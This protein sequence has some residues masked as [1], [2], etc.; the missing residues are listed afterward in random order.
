MDSIQ[1]KVEYS[2]EQEASVIS[3][4]VNDESLIE[5]MKRYEAQFEPEIA[6]LYEGLNTDLVD[7]IEAHFT[8]RLQEDDIFNYEG[9][10]LVLGCNCGLPGCWPLLVKITETGDSIIWSHFEQPHRTEDSAGG[11]WDYSNFPPLHFQKREYIEQL[12]NISRSD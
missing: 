3:I 8:G 2:E 9:K 5:R 12:N 10:T 11:Y 1:F 4:Y 7:H 6:G